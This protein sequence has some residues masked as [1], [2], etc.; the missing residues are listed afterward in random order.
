MIEAS[1]DQF[2]LTG[3]QRTIYQKVD[4]T[5]AEGEKEEIDCGV[6]WTTHD[7]FGLL[8]QV[9]NLYRISVSL[10]LEALQNEKMS[11]AFV[12]LRGFSFSSGSI[13]RIGQARCASCASPSHRKVVEAL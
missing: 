10:R 12:S 8:L 9:C 5:T 3:A 7:A 4:R 11:I 13:G 2:N 6:P 1:T